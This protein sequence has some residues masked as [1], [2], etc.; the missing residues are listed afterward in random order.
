[1]GW[2]R[3]KLDRLR[4]DEG[5]RRSATI[6]EWSETQ[7]GCTLIAGA[8]PRSVVR[9]AGVVEALRVRP[10]QGVPQIEAQ[11]SDGTG[12]VT[13]VWVGRRSI[14]GLALGV[15]MIVEGRLAGNS[16]EGLQIMNPR[17]E[18]GRRQGELL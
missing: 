17:F 6:R 16:T 9:L 11:I 8:E 13:A 1:M 18:F 10:R 3:R 15:R 12:A 5:E 7:E 4:Q 2:L 14:P